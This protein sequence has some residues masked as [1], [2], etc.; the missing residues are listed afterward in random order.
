[1][2]ESAARFAEKR[3]NLSLTA[4]RAER[5]RLS[6]STRVAQEYTSTMVK[7]LAEK[8]NGIMCEENYHDKLLSELN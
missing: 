5:G 3:E 7:L 2:T 1:M 4:E 6:A 8:Y